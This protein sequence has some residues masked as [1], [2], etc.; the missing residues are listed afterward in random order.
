MVSRG[1]HYL[2]FRKFEEEED[3]SSLNQTE[4]SANRQA[5]S[6]EDDCVICL[7]PIGVCPSSSPQEN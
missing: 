3:Y 4:N 7:S 1:A 2:Y 5:V 6:R